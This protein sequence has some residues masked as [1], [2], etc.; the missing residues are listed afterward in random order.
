MFKPLFKI[1]TLKRKLSVLM[2]H[3][4]LPEHDFMRPHEMTADIFTQHLNYLTANFTLLTLSDALNKLHS[5]TL[6]SNAAVMTFD[7]G[8]ENNASIALP[9]LNQHGVPASFYIATDFLNGGA[10][11]NDKI[12]EAA[13]RWPTGL[14]KVSIGD[15]NLEFQI[16]DDKSRAFAGGELLS[17]F[18]YLPL[19]E[20]AVAVDEFTREVIDGLNYM[21]SDAQ[22]KLLHDN[23]MEIG[24]HTCS[25]PILSGLTESKAFQ[26]ISDNK[27]YLESILGQKITSFAYPNGKP[28]KD[29]TQQ[30]IELVKRAGY[31]YAVSTHEG[32]ASSA[33][34]KYQ[35]P[36]FTPWRNNKVGFNALLAKNYLVR[37]STGI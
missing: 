14:L 7:D 15:K 36:R 33:T 28:G 30:T 2:Y 1:L 4:V 9:M 17:A 13:R 32:V 24:G 10:M 22:V 29:Y 11:W 19:S 26:Q 21:M 3:Q 34:D 35:V 31:E 37:E 16:S 5:N 6:P 12:L 18:K 25:H 23:G 27:Q 8:Y 20:R